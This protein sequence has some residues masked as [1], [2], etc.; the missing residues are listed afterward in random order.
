[1]HS[2]CGIGHFVVQVFIDVTGCMGEVMGN[3]VSVHVVV[4][5]V[6][7]TVLTLRLEVEAD[8]VPVSRPHFVVWVCSMSEILGERKRQASSFEESHLSF[9]VLVFACVVLKSKWS[10]YLK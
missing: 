8:I 2:R 1:M 9:K 6:D 3:I 7:T 5:D 10:V 4:V